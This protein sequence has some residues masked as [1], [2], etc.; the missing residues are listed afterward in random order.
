MVRILT[1]E[2]EPNQEPQR[3]LEEIVPLTCCHQ[4][5]I[6]RSNYYPSSEQ[7]CADCDEKHRIHCEQYIQLYQ[8]N[9]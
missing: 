3:R 2:R 9:V 4:F 8:R 7:R 5:R 6:L 1:M